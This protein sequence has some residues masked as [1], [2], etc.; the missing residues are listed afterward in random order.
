MARWGE[1]VEATRVGGNGSKFGR[2]VNQAVQVQKPLYVLV[3]T[4]S[5][6]DTDTEILQTD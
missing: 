3:Q 2:E 6:T 5:N 4:R 1:G